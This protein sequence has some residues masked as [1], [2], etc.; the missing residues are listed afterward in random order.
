MRDD[1]RQPDPAASSHLDA[2]AAR[3]IAGDEFALA[4]LHEALTP[5]L[6]RHFLRKL[7]GQRRA[8][9]QAEE[10]AQA[11]WVQVW[12]LLQRGAYDPQRARLT[13]Y[14]Y[15]V[16]HIVWMRAMREQER[17]QQRDGASLDADG[18]SGDTTRALVEGD[19]AEDALELTSQIEQVREVL[20][21][22]GG[23]FTP[24]ERDALRAIA[25]GSTDRELA[26]R[27]GVAASTANERR[28]TLLAR[29]AKWLG[30]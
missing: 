15:G 10:L 8:I 4:E 23:G 13:T 1:P 27:L 21:G 12:A 6:T 11:A 25:E 22:R 2:L 19:A 26:K 30:G 20:A 24:A 18:V 28:K 17:R 29:L 5:G 14:I 7:G 3:V 16:A 9:E